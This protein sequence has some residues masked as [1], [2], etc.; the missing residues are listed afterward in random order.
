MNHV[1]N[2]VALAGEVVEVLEKEGKQFGKI[3]FKT[4]HIYVPMDAICDAHLGDT[5]AIEADITVHKV[6][7]YLRGVS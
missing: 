2:R 3:L 5:V 7:A 4:C 1:E 6:E